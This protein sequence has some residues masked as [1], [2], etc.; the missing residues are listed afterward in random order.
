MKEIISNNYEQQQ[1]LS[2]DGRFQGISYL[3]EFEAKTGFFNASLYKN[4]KVY[5]IA[6]LNALIH[7]LLKAVK[8]HSEKIEI[9]IISFNIGDLL[10]SRCYSK[11]PEI[12]G[13]YQYLLKIDHH[14]PSL[15]K[16]ISVRNR[17]SHVTKDILV[18]ILYRDKIVIEMQLGIK[19][20]KSRFIECSD[21]MN[22]FIY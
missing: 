16:V 20:D 6:Y 12:I 8:Q 19:S 18:N 2:V 17:L 22:H 14:N 1:L 15:F 13:L 10:R 21:K 4:S 3:S 11:E 9:D 5:L 7:G